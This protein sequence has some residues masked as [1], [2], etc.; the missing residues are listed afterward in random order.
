MALVPNSNMR[1]GAGT[2]GKVQLL[3]RRDGGRRHET[4]KIVT[5]STTGALELGLQK[6]K[7][8]GWTQPIHME[9]RQRGGEGTRCTP[10]SVP[11]RHPRQVLGRLACFVTSN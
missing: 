1:K 5:F 8:N 2:K 4:D 11:I 6:R 3:K 9:K 7:T 10:S